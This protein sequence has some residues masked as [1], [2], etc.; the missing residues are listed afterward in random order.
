ML[1]GYTKTVVCWFV[2]RGMCLAVGLVAILAAAAQAQQVVDPR[3]ITF[4]LT[5]MPEPLAT[6]PTL[7]YDSE[8]KPV[9]LED[10]RGK[11]VLLNVWATWCAPCIYEMPSLDKLQ[12]RYKAAGLEVVPVAMDQNGTAESIRSFFM[13][14]KIK[15]LPVFFDP[16][17]SVSKA[18]KVKSLPSSYLIDHEGKL[19][20]MLDGADDWYSN[21]AQAAVEALLKNLPSRQIRKPKLPL[22]DIET[23]QQTGV[24]ID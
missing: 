2:K 10:F 8:G 24:R 13:R 5:Y 12:R 11:V 21:P 15:Y 1:F 23:H 9:R 19:V 3:D 7:F 22:T 4:K 14:Y 17:Q 16:Q 6:Q 18:F 20:A